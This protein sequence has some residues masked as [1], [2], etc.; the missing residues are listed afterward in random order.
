MSIP[1]P[2]RNQ[3]FPPLPTH[4]IYFNSLFL[5][6]IWLC[7]EVNKY[8]QKTTPSSVQNPQLCCSSTGSQSKDWEQANLPYQRQIQATQF[9]SKPP[10]VPESSTSVARL[11]SYYTVAGY[12]ICHP[13]QP[14]HVQ[15]SC[16]A[17]NMLTVSS[18]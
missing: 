8:V 9:G 12:S 6:D 13:L 14:F 10:Q 3:R 5:S 18:I 15:R 16:P 1:V 11:H 2:Q 17:N 4:L 7:N